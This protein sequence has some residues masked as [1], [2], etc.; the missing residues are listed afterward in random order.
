MY[1]DADKGT[2]LIKSS[3][4]F[5]LDSNLENLT[6]AGTDNINGTGNSLANTITG[7]AG[8]NT[9]D[10]GTGTDALIGGAGNDTYVLGADSDSISDSAGIDKITSTVSR[11]L[12]GYATIENLTLTGTAAINGTGNALANTI[13]G[14]SGN[15]TLDGGTGTDALIGGAG[16][17]TYVLGADSD[18]ISD[19][20]DT[21]T[22]TSTVSRSLAA[23]ATIENL[24]LTGTTAINGIGNS[25]AN[26]IT[27]NAGNN[28]LDGGA[29]NDRLFGGLGMDVLIGGAGKDTFIFDTKLGTG[30]IDRIVDFSAKD[31]TIWLDDDIFT[32]IGKVGDLSVDAFY[33][34]TAAH[35]A[36]DRVIWDKASGK[37]FYDADGSGIG[38]AIQF[39]LLDKGLTL[40]VADFDLIT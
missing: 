11:S 5:W 15:N 8:N 31:D 20:A 36:S 18:S 37:L 35:D 34:G 39:A 25:L 7:N 33:I 22:I 4:S 10:G 28:M 9:L 24:T 1:E 38:A 2:D 26:T 19:S 13:T 21:D 23:Y 6:L 40:T 30:N 3:V 17:D 29:G 27:G 16:N 12:A 32:Q 14:N